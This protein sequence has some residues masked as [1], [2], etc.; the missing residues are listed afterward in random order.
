VFTVEERD[1]VRESLLERAAKDPGV[2]AAAITGSY[3]A[4][5]GDEWS[6]IDLAF[7]IDGELEPAL[8]HWTQVV[9]GEFGAIHHWDLPWGSTVYRV[10][11]LPRWLQLDIAFTPAADF[12]PRGPNWRT[13]FGD[14][15]EPALPPAPDPNDVI[16]FG[17]LWARHARVCIDRGNPWQAEY[18]ISGLRD[19]VLALACLRLGYPTRYARGV[20]L[21]PQDVTAPLAS[22]LVRSVDERELRRALAAGATAYAEELGRTDEALA[23]TLRPLLEEL[24]AQ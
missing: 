21:L 3:T 12:G 9:V 7:G 13:V 8:T 10:F 1:R 22:A 18:C 15:V 16:G 19:N 2:V 4:G 6:D 24:T 23:R 14:T 17:W 11:L 5:G 20:D